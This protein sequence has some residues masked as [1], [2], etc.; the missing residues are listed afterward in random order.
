MS[1]TQMRRTYT[2][3]RT[4]LDPS[5]FVSFSSSTSESEKISRSSEEH[6]EV[7]I[8]KT[9]RTTEIGSSG[10]TPEANKSDQQPVRFDSGP[11]SEIDLRISEF[12]KKLKDN[13]DPRKSKRDLVEE[14]IR[15]NASEAFMLNMTAISNKESARLKGNKLAK[16]SSILGSGI[17][18]QLSSFAV[19]S[20]AAYWTNQAW[21]FPILSTI[22]S[23]VFSDKAAALT[24]RT[25]FTTNDAKN[26]YRKQRLIAR[27]FGDMIRQYYGLKPAAKY[28]TNN[29]EYKGQKFT[30]WDALWKDN[31]SFLAV[32]ANNMVNRG[33]PFLCFTG[34]YLA[35]DFLL[36]GMLKGA[37]WWQTFL[38]RLGSGAIAGALT[39]LSNQLITS[40]NKDA[41]ETPGHSTSYWHAKENYLC[42]VRQD[43]RER[44]NESRN[45]SDQKLKKNL[46]N[47]LLDLDQKIQREIEVAKLKKSN[48]TAIAG[49]LKA[50]AHR[51]RPEDSLDPEAP[52]SLAQSLHNACGKFISLIYFTYM[53]DQVMRSEIKNESISPWPMLNLMFMP[54]ALTLVG[55]IWREDLQIISRIGYATVKAYRDTNIGRDEYIDKNGPQLDE[56]VTDVPDEAHND[57]ENDNDNDNDND[58]DNRVESYLNAHS[59]ENQLTDRELEARD[60]KIAYEKKEKESKTESYPNKKSGTFT[61]KMSGSSESDD[62]SED[63]TQ[64]SSSS[65]KVEGNS[66]S[67]SSS[68]SVSSTKTYD[69]GD[70]SSS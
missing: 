66:S 36:Q 8:V 7:A 42:S 57:N 60:R 44:L 40:M 20:E 17:V 21:L 51:S 45:I 49:E 52:G 48:W 67:T 38:L 59:S 31:D 28:R 32:S 4:D 22:C 13:K 2:V 34:T 16:W 50:S 12:I 25:T 54:F 19:G 24:R 61:K 5:I 65:E 70:Y 1:K 33:L 43:I 11:Q 29:P 64:S 10:R 26:L 39:A 18:S 56:V 53:L 27:A 62:E 9:T 6:S 15:T 69:D 3:E 30:A 63:D 47:L 14:F 46:E 68:V 55:Y 37:P 58:A 35:R 23:E 41:S